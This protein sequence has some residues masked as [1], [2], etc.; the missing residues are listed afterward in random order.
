MFGPITEMVLDITRNRERADSL[1][2]VD[3]EYRELRRGNW[4]GFELDM[5]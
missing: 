1:R 4:L 5:Y 2:D 3:H